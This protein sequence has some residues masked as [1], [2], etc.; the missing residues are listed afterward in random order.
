MLYRAGLLF[1]VVLILTTTAT[2]AALSMPSASPT[3][4]LSM[5]IMPE[6]VYLFPTYAQ[7][8]R[9]E[10]L[11]TVYCDKTRPDEIRVYIEGWV[12]V[13]WDFHIQPE[14]LVFRGV[15]ERQHT[16]KIYLSVPPRTAGPPQIDM[17]FRAYADLAGRNV[18]CTASSVLYIVQDVHGFI[19]SI[20]EEI[21][22]P[23]DGGIDGEVYIENLLDEELEV[24]IS[25]SEEWASMV[26]ELDFQ[27][28]IVLQ[29]YEQRS[30]RF[31]GRISDSVEPGDYLVQ[32]DLW[33]PGVDGERTVITMANVTLHVMEDP[34]DSFTFN[35]LRNLVPLLLVIGVAV[36]LAAYLFLRRRDR[37]ST[38][39]RKH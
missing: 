15:G 25:A 29:P 4:E 27:L 14:I 3:V 22:V 16:F 37:L 12:D 13:P 1:V 33:T 2:P 28:D 26:P 21:T 18:E 5:E 19:E 11:G 6:E 35:L 20:P 30:A 8:G 34:G 10:F 9:L 17:G 36:S 23:P 32:L 31:H 24:H 39:N 38:T 7:V